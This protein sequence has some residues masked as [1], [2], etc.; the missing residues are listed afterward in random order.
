LEFT[1]LLASIAAVSLLVG[2]DRDHQHP[3]GERHRADPGDGIRMAI[4]AK[5]RTILAQFL[6]E[7]LV[8][9]TA[10]G[11]IGVGLGV[12]AARQLSERFS[13]PLLISPDIILVAVGF[14]AL[15]GVVFGLY[16]ARK[17]SLLDPIE[18]LRYE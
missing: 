3:A 1:T 7:A 12:L 2:G 15:V 8:L 13:W 17:A 11:L 6:A 18:A 9:S 10:G 14:S 5:P 16:P 4:G